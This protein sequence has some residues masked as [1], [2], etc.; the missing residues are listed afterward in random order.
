MVLNYRVKFLAWQLYKFMYIKRKKEKDVRDFLETREILAVVGPRQAGK[1]TMLKKIF[2]DLRKEKAEKKA[3][4]ISFEDRNILSLFNSDIK[5]FADTYVSGNDFLFID[6]FQYSK[7]GGQKL[8]YLF[9]TFDTKLIISGSSAIDLTVEAIKFLVGR[10]FVIE[11]QVFDFEEFLS[12]KDPNY[13]HLYQKNKIDFIS[14]DINKKFAKEQIKTF[15]KYFEEYA[16]WGGYP[17]VVISAGKKEKEMVLKNIYNTYFLKEVKS[18]MDIA[19]DYQ[20]EKMI[21]LLALQIG[22]LIE[23]QNF[24]NETNISFET[25]KKYLNFLEKTYISKLVQPFYNNKRK[26]IVKTPKVYFFDTGLRN[27][28]VNDFRML[29]DRTDSGE[30]LENAVWAQITRQE[31]PTQYWR[32]KNKN[33]IDFILSLPG[34]KKVAVEVKRSLLK[35]GELPSSFQK[36]YPDIARFC[37]YLKSSEKSFKGLQKGGNIFIPLI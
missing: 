33:E 31:I 10:V 28:V 20:F 7:K 5:N 1:T 32:D 21:K 16:I 8:K 11:L 18:L 13:Y 26:E 3:S 22:S 6:E 4:F 29:D 19:N 37:A 2:D 30:L 23:Y 12:F 15:Q 14:L 27:A 35:C 34:N 36:N 25:V 17:R 24:T 9:D